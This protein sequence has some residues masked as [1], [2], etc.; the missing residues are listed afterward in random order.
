MI[1]WQPSS[2]TTGTGALSILSHA[3][4]VREAGTFYCGGPTYGFPFEVAGHEAEAVY[5]HNS[6][7]GHAMRGEL[8]AAIVRRVETDGTYMPLH[9]VSA[10][11]TGANQISVTLSEAAELATDAVVT[12]IA[13][14]GI[15]LTGGTIAS[16]SVAGDQLVITTTGAAS[17][18]SAVR[19]GLTG[20]TSPRTAANVPRTN[21]RATRPL[22]TY[23]WG[24]LI[25]AWACHQ[26]I[27]VI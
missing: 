22:G 6:S 12:A 7:R 8:A 17:A 10:R 9:A 26:S 27:D 13:D 11:V 19:F 25:R 16:V 20:Q 3:Q 24:G 18:V 1:S 23:S 14:H 15:T 21:I 5:L 2:F 4:S